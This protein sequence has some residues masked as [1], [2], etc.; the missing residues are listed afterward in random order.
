[1]TV[2]SNEQ[3]ASPEG[4]ALDQNIRASM[5]RVG[6][7]KDPTPQDMARVQELLQQRA[8]SMLNAVTREL[9]ETLDRAPSARA[10][11]T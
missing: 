7:A 9:N 8:R 3:V 10:V 2:D 1:M 11:V 4:L 6:S 5:A